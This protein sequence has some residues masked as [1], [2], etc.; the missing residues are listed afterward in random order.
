M[1]NNLDA[2]ILSA[3]K[4]GRIGEPKALLKFNGKSFIAN[5]LEKLLP[6]CNKIVIVLGYQSKQIFTSIVNEKIYSDHQEKI[7][8]EINENFE[9]GMFSSIQSGLKQFRNSNYV[10]IH[11]VDQPGLPQKFY[12]EFASQIDER[13]DWLQPS[14]Q[15]RLGH[16]I[17]INKKIVNLILVEPIDSNLRILKTKHQIIQKIW[18]CS[19]PEIHQDIDTIEDYNKLLGGN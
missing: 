18:E 1:Q 17:I 9:K 16:P 13:I 14:Y 15:G 6:L 11:Q 4:S 7:F 5:I 10:L 12:N 2:I 19:Y 3:G 8:I